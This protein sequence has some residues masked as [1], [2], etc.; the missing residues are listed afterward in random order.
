MRYSFVTNAVVSFSIEVEA[1]SLEEAIDKAAEAPIM[2]LCHQCSGGDS[3]DE[4][5]TE[6]DTDQPG[7][8]VDLWCGDENKGETSAEFMLAKETFS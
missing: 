2:S 4:W 1:D 3:P 6:L 8:L 5:G 7:A